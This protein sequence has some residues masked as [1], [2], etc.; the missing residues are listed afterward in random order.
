M[1]HLVTTERG[2]LVRITIEF[3]PLSSF[4]STE[5]EGVT[6]SNNERMIGNMGPNARP[7]IS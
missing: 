1:E 5:Q 7:G 6:W 4:V 2:V 3:I